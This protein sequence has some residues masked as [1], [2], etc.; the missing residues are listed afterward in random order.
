MWCDIGLGFRSG[1]GYGYASGLWAL[2]LGIL[3]INTQPSGRA[4]DHLAGEAVHA[5]A[6]EG[7]RLIALLQIVDEQLAGGQQMEFAVW[8]IEK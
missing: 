2:G 3:T 7:L 4:D 5:A 8:G 1:S 6:A